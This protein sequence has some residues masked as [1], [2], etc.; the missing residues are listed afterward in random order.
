MSP[1]PAIELEH[2]RSIVRTLPGTTEKVS[3]DAPVFFIDGTRGRSFAWFWHNHHGDG[4]TALLVKTSGL[5]EQEMLIEADPDLYFKPPYLGPSGWIGV[6]LDQDSTDWHHVADWIE[7][8]W[9]SVAPR[10]L[11]E[12]WNGGDAAGT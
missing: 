4:R 8:S 6:L 2:V 1:D 10:K 11:L 12:G 9:R 5:E 3:H 7:R